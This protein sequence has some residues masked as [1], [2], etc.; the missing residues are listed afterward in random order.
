MINKYEKIRQETQKE[1]EMK[2]YEDD[3][4]GR[5]KESKRRGFVVGAKARI[6]GDSEIGE[7]VG[8]EESGRRYTVKV[9]FK[10]GI[11]SYTIR[12]LEL[13]ENEEK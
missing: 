8:Y 11:F 10:R 6:I 1:A 12:E 9:K 13:V 5:I 3:I 7:I 2:R 4:E